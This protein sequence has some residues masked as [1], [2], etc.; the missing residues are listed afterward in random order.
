[1]AGRIYLLSDD[2]KLVGMDEASYDSEALLQEM[3]ANH[4]DLLAGEQINSEEPRRW[5][6][7]SRE[8]SVPDEEEGSGRWSLDHLFLDQAAVP[9]LVEVKRSSDTRIRREVIGQ[10]LDYAANAVAYWPVEEIRAKFENRCELND[11]DAEE[12]ISALLGED[13]DVGEFWKQVK[14]N[15]QAGRIRMVFVADSIPAEL[16]RVIEFLNEQMD[17]AEVLAVEV[18]QF[19]G[20]GMK[21]LVPRVLGQTETAR[22][23]KA[24]GTSSRERIADVDFMADVTA[25]RSEA[26][27]KIIRQ[28][29]EWSRGRGLEDNFRR[30]QRG[31][32]FLPVLK[33]SGRK[34]Y[35]LSVQQR[36]DV[37]IQMRWLKDHPPFDNAEKRAELLRRI[38]T[39]P[40]LRLTDAGMEGFPKV[41]IA[42]LSDD[43]QLETLVHALDWIVTEVRASQTT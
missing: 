11:E 3:L 13:Q 32:A 29:V 10:M 25:D 2:S 20:E 23:K 12:S 42:S 19:V 36:G 5:L 9:T 37:V 34:C 40:G 35:P 30:G 16:R 17:P 6:L 7:V 39:L 21:T 28:L 8:M 41:S 15:L 27:V 33:H 31:A 26:E 24:S 22:Q 43:S 38:Q 4:P 14:T 1:M 18:K